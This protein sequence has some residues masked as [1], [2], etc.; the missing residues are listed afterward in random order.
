M[1]ISETELNYIS[2]NLVF[3]GIGDRELREDL[4]DHICSYIE[5]ADG[6][7]FDSA[8]ERA[9]QNLGGYGAMQLLQHDKNEKHLMS[10]I[11]KR[12]KILYTLSSLNLMVLCWGLLSKIFQW[13]LANVFIAVALGVLLFVTL[14]FAFYEKYRNDCQKIKLRNR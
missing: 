5:N 9:I 13:P 1:T 8:Y 4:T 2:T 14:P 3:H 11:L 6:T 7:E 10:G 12:K